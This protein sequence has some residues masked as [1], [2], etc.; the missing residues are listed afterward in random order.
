MLTKYGEHKIS[1]HDALC[2]AV[3][4]RTRIY[5]IFTFDR[6]FQILGFQVIPGSH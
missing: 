3:M 5:Q 2:A 1:H 6:D 4:L